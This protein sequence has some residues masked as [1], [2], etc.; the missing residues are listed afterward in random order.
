MRGR[1][2][3]AATSEDAVR[4][5]RICAAPVALFVCDACS[6]GRFWIRS[7]PQAPDGVPTRMDVQVLAGKP[8]CR[9]K[10]RSEIGTALRCARREG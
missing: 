9:A 10:V 7:H 4:C 3:A 8:S 1:L 5:G 6:A 2:I